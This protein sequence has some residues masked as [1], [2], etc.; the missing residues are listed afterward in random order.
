[1]S[2][3]DKI[4][5][6]DYDDDN[7]DYQSFSTHLEEHTVRTKNRI[8]DDFINMGEDL[9][10]E[11]EEKNAR[12]NILKQKQITYILKH[13]KG[14]YSKRTLEA[15][16]FDDVKDIYNEIKEKRGVFRKI[17]NFVFNL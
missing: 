1:M 2:V 17:F 10:G 6:V 4:L 11:I 14:V 3:D 15:Y 8:A 7:N 13:D 9:L 16:S 5:S 12:K